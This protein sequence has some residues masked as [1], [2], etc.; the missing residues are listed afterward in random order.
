MTDLV[1]LEGL[2]VAVAT[3]INALQ[4]LRAIAVQDSRLDKERVEALL[5]RAQEQADRLYR[6]HLQ[7]AQELSTAA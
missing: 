4:V 6:L 1:E 5:E 3:K 2:R 7:V